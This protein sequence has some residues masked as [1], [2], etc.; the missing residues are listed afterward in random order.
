MATPHVSGA[1][2]LVLSR[3]DLDTPALKRA[4]LETVEPVASLAPYTIT[5]G[6]LDV[7]S[8]VRSCMRPAAPDD[9]VARG[10]DHA[11]N[12]S[13]TR[14]PG[15][16]GYSVR[17]SVT[18]G[19]PYTALRTITGATY[20]DTAVT[21]GTRYFYVV[22]AS[23]LSGRE[24]VIRGG[25]GHAESAVRSRGLG[26]RGSDDGRSRAG[27]CRDREYA[28]PGHRAVAADHDPVLPLEELPLGRGRQLHRPAGGSGAC[29][30]RAERCVAL[31]GA[32]HTFAERVSA[33]SWPRADADAVENETQ[34]ANNTTSRLITIGPDLA[35]SSLTVPASAGAGTAMVV[36]TTV[37][38]QGGGAAG[39]SVARFYLSV[40]AAFDT[41]DTLVD[42][43][44][45][46][47]ALAPGASASGA[48]SLAIPPGLAAGS[49]Y[50][51]AVADGDGA[52][53]ETQEANNAAARLVQV[54]G[55]LVVSAIT[56]PAKAAAGGS[57]VVTD[58]VR[59]SGAGA[60]AAS[61]TRFYLSSN[62]LLDA[63]DALLAGGRSVPALAA[64]A[65][66]T[67]SATLVL[68]SELA[69]G[70]WYVIAKADG[71]GTVTETLET[72]NTLS[73]SLTVGPDLVVSAM[74]VPYNV[75]AG[76]SIPVS[77]TVLN[78]GADP[79]GPAVT[80]FYLSANVALDSADTLLDGARPVAT[81]AGG[82][83]STGTTAITI[84]PGTPAGAW[85]VIA[86]ADASDGVVE[87]VE[88]NNTAARAVQVAP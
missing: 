53:V 38:N 62:A 65:S 85:F 69:A 60:I 5:G 3:C 29:E 36:N 19:G 73:R 10:A 80:R 45:D 24:R 9:L 26:A 71:D 14:V 75:R 57:V 17:R 84:P 54:G 88:G 18:A 21:N 22:T 30:R 61:V 50:L 46:V 44:L 63:A 55:D 23:N 48:S 40:N 51:I 25:V 32:A 20:A 47:P 35:V 4:L 77:D 12:L 2:A 37:K 83:A 41:S 13:W 49:Y 66:S 11:V 56:A 42:G 8:A 70:T 39:A 6:R 64:G 79:A 59:N 72:N 81:L 27:D 78:Q 7:G 16:M 87:S 34:E 1:A 76:T 82:G 33:T 31:A 86:K 52:V 58:T 15:A 43:T 74:S 67:G 28:Q 68:P